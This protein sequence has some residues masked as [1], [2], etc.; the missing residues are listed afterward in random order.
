MEELFS[1]LKYKK[2][3]LSKVICRIDFSDLLSETCFSELALG[4]AIES[5]FPIRGKDQIEN[6][7]NLNVVKTMGE[8]PTVSED[9][10]TLIRKEFIDKAGKNRCYISKQC[11]VLDYSKYLNFENLQ[12]DLE[13]LISLIS[14]KQ[15]NTLVSRFGLRYINE[16]NP[17][18]IKL[19]KNHFSSA[20]N[21]I[22][23]FDS[24]P[25][26]V[27]SRAMGQLEY[28][29]ED[30]RLVTRYGT[31]NR[32]YPGALQRNDFVLDYDSFVQGSYKLADLFPQK[33]ANAHGMIQ[34]AFESHIT[35]K[36]RDIMN[37][38]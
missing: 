20:I 11:I 5:H 8:A 16:Y 34:A 12:S 26:M 29:Q 13:K 7:S 9:T 38:G 24:Y 32:N 23:D 6:V 10:F 33:I 15:N 2:H 18:S 27:L 21:S 28:I 1:E 14:D 3:F 19:Q 37:K 25:I 30:I 17:E 31:Y 22:L 36:L 35:E 4:T